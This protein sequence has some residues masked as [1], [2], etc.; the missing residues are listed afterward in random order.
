MC[1][2]SK[3]VFNAEKIFKKFSRKSSIYLVDFYT[4][5]TAYPG[6]I[7]ILQDV[8]YLRN[9]IVS[10]PVLTLVLHS[11]ANRLVPNRDQIHNYGTSNAEMEIG[12]KIQTKSYK[13]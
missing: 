1:D 2:I 11:V 6:E 9:P 5:D 7:I 3:R 12:P 4:R 10:N 8:P 13:F